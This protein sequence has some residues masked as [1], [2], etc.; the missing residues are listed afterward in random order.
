METSFVCSV[1]L[2][3][4]AQPAW[5]K[6]SSMCSYSRRPMPR[7][8]RRGPDGCCTPAALAT[9]PRPRPRGSGRAAHLRDEAEP[10][11]VAD[12]IPAQLHDPVAQEGRLL[13]L[14]VLRRVLHLLLQVLY[15]PR[16]LVLRDGPGDVG[17]GL[18][19][20]L[21]DAVRY[22]AYRLADPLRLDA[23]LT[24]GL[25]LGAAG[26]L[27]SPDGATHRV[28]DPVGVHDHHAAD[29]PGSASHRLDQ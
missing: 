17:G 10:F 5:R 13:E 29:V 28:G 3:Q 8:R 9:A 12:E 20:H 14:Q 22:V 23:V 1:E 7:R 11:L 24:V 15:Q 25:L 27:R 4:K 16:D 6:P 21:A 19:R 26:A 2:S 18:L